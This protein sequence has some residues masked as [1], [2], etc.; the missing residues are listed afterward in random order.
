V[1]LELSLPAGGTVRVELLD[2]S[3]AR[4]RTLLRGSLPAGR[5][6][7]VWDGRTVAGTAAP[8]GIYVAY[9]RAPGGEASARIALLR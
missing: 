9:V 1:P 5:H 6:P 7:I 3:G 8:P 2:V 4:V